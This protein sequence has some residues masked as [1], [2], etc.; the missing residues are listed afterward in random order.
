[1][2]WYSNLLGTKQEYKKV[3]QGILFFLDFNTY[4]AVIR[5]IV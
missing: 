4:V 2:F 5:D 1:M 3:S